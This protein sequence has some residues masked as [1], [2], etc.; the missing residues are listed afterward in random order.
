MKKKHWGTGSDKRIMSVLLRSKI[1]GGF[2]GCGLLDFRGRLGEMVVVVV[3]CFAGGGL[4][5]W[6]TV[7]VDSSCAAEIWWWIGFGGS[8]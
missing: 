3:G 5:E 4:W 6:V 8:G 2:W 1:F 7:A